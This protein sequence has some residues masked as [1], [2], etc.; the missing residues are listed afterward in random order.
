MLDLKA[1]TVAEPP[2]HDP[3]VTILSHLDTSTKFEEAVM[4]LELKA[5]KAGLDLDEI[6]SV[7]ECR[8][9]ALEEEKQEDEEEE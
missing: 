2:S 9:Y 1:V 8:E 3:L 5:R 6:I 4:D 7:Y